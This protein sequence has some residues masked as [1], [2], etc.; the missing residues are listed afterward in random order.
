MSRLLLTDTMYREAPTASADESLLAAA[1]RMLGHRL[2]G[3]PVVEGRQL[4]GALDVVDL[5]PRLE[6]VPFSTME[7][8]RLFDEW[9]DEHNLDA[10]R[11][12]FESRTVGEVMR[13]DPVVHE[14][15]DTMAQAVETMA[16]QNVDYVF[17]TDSEGELQGMVTRWLALS[18]ILREA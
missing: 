2:S 9:V 1:V 3:M 11:P 13:H 8:I 15:E 4:V 6:P 16:R 17:V 18:L 7:A 10:L 12:A 5:L 14:P